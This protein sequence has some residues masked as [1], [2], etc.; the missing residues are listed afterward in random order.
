MVGRSVFADL[1]AHAHFPRLSVGMGARDK[2]THRAPPA[3]LCC[4]LP[5]SPPPP[6]TPFVGA[7]PCASQAPYAH[8]CETPA[9]ACLP[10]TNH[11][12]AFTCHAACLRYPLADHACS[13]RTC[14]LVNTP[15][16]DSPAFLPYLDLVRHWF[17]DSFTTATYSSGFLPT[18]FF[19]STL[20]Y[21]TRHV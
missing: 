21:G 19:L 1:P 18:T 6:P 15:T 11:A 10:G 5:T 8:R 13:Q 17:I 12:T 20:N 3:P 16:L 4:L 7:T 9:C 2:T 14:R